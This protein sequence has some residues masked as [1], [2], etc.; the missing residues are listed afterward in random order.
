MIET[1]NITMRFRDKTLKAMERMMEDLGAASIS[2]I[3]RRCII[4]EYYKLYKEMP[5]DVVAERQTREV[6]KIT[7][8]ESRIM[9]KEAICE[10]LDGKIT[11]KGGIKTCHYTMYEMINPNCV[12]K[13][14][15]SLPIDLLDQAVIDSQY[16]PDKDTC[17]KILTK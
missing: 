13:Y 11:E 2:E 6:K 7:K 5:D 9:S 8:E 16:T 3:V 12:E 4:N 14:A 1:K 17:I 10:R 15:Q